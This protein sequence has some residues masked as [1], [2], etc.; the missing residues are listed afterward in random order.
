MVKLKEV[1]CTESLDG[2]TIKIQIFYSVFSSVDQFI[3]LSI[4]NPLDSSSNNNTPY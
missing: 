3:E 2:H 4:A 1:I